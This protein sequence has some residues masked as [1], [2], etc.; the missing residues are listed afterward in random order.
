MCLNRP[1]MFTSQK[2]RCPL[3]LLGLKSFHG[4]VILV[5]RREPIACFE[6]YLVIKMWENPY[7]K[8]YQK[9]KKTKRFETHQTQNRNTQEETNIILQIC[10]WIHIVPTNPLPFTEGG[11]QKLGKLRK[12]GRRGDHFI[13]KSSGKKGKG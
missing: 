3:C 12:F 2:S 6:F 4:F 5:G 13:K 1:K 10:R 7:K 11:E 9:R 8:S